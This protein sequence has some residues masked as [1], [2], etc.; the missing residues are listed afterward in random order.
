MFHE[1]IPLGFA[2]IPIVA[3]VTRHRRRMTELQLIHRTDALESDQ[4]ISQA[5]RI[6]D[7]EDRIRVLERIVTDG[8]QAQSIAAEIEALRS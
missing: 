1:L 5:R 4:A 7:L 8:R 2:A 6:A 3:I